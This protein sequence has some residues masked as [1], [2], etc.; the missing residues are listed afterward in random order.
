MRL[1]GLLVIAAA[2]GADGDDGDDTAHAFCVDETNRYRA[3]H[4]RPA[5]ARSAA[6]EDFASSPHA[7]FIRTNG[8]G[9]AF[10]ENE[11]PHWGLQAQG[12][13][14][15]HA[16]VAA[17]IAAFYAE[18]PGGG[19]Y[20]NMMGNYGTLGCGIF[21]SGDSVTIVQDFGR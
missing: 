13:G 12:G 15:L 3:M 11:C 16:L 7:H 5:V 4:G 21:E 6:A 2:C 10:A 18:G 19:H 14:D 20:D 1:L 8:G 9:I 17:C